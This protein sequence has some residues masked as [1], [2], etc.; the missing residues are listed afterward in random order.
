MTQ[1][2]MVE[3]LEFLYLNEAHKVLCIQHGRFQNE[4]WLK[5]YNMN[6]Y[7]QDYTIFIFVKL[8]KAYRKFGKKCKNLKTYFV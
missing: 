5:C 7:F 4:Q 6:L 1:Y 3:I 8:T 2:S